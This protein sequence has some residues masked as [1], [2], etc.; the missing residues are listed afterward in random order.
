MNNDGNEDRK[1]KCQHQQEA[2]TSRCSHVST[3]L[4]SVFSS[5]NSINQS[6]HRQDKTRQDKQVEWQTNN[7]CSKL[8]LIVLLTG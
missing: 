4:I 3:F 6:N 1:N 8:N 5:F 7:T 2:F